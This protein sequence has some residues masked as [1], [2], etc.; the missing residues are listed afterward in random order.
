MPV[1]SSKSLPHTVIY[2]D[3]RQKEQKEEESNTNLF[4]RTN[5]SLIGSFSKLTCPSIRTRFFWRSSK[6]LPH[7][8]IYADDRQKEQKGEES[9]TN[10]FK[11][12]N[13]SLIGSF[14]KLLL[15]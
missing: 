11:R 12:T 6:S 3:D 4:K 1:P 14:S 8:V 13:S 5:S 15:M 2:A 7:T 10:L 9:N